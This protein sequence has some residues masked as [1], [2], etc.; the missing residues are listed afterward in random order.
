[1]S[2]TSCSCRGCS[3]ASDLEGRHE[4]AAVPVEASGDPCQGPGGLFYASDRPDRT[5][6]RGRS[7]GAPATLALSFVEAQPARSSATL[8]RRVLGALA[9]LL[10]HARGP[11][12]S[13]TSRVI[14]LADS[15]AALARSAIRSSRLGALGQAHQRHVLVRAVIPADL[16]ASPLSRAR[17]RRGRRGRDATGPPRSRFSGSDLLASV[18]RY[19]VAGTPIW[20]SATPPADRQARRRGGTGGGSIGPTPLGRGLST[21]L[22][23]VE[24]GP[25]RSTNGPGRTTLPAPWSRHNNDG[26]GSTKTAGLI[27]QPWIDRARS[28]YRHRRRRWAVVVN[29]C[30]TVSPRPARRC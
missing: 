7:P 18:D 20:V 23:I 12:R 9:R 29:R 3:R 22:S 4:L 27:E 25:S 30:S 24:R 17:A 2:K 14:R 19:R 13:S 10:H 1:M 26:A 28:D 6:G 5:P 16:H 21:S 15:A 8:P 11:C